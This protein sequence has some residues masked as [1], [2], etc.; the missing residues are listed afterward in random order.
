MVWNSDA[1]RTVIED[2]S[3]SGRRVSVMRER[4]FEAVVNAS[5]FGCSDILVVDLL[6][7]IFL[8]LCCCDLAID[9]SRAVGTLFEK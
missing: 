8:L 1:L 9:K 5:G 4:I 6:E 2:D 3:H 7:S